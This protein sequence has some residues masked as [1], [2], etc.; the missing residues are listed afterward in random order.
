VSKRVN[1]TD[2]YLA[3]AECVAQRATCD[4]KTVGC[5]LVKGKHL[6]S[7]GYNGAPSG[8]AHCDN[9]GH[10]IE[11]VFG[12]NGED[13]RC[14][15]AVH[16]EVNAVAQAARHGSKTEGTT[17]YVTHFPCASCAKVLVNAGVVEVVAASAGARSVEGKAVFNE[18]GVPW[19]VRRS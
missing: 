6:V 11:R 10:D 9:V 5:V 14:S 13:E 16:A 4:R 19:I 3:I 1:L 8:A 17:A 12:R 7:S 15:R 2:Y 18:C